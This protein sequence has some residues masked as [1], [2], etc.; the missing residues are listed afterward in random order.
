MKPLIYV[1]TAFFAIFGFAAFCAALVTIA[2][3]GLCEWTYPL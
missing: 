2:A 3:N 1:L